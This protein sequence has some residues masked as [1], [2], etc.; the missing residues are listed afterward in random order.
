[1]IPRQLRL[2][3]LEK[4]AQT[5]TTTTTAPTTP[6]G[7]KGKSQ[8]AS[9]LMPTLANGWGQLVSGI[10]SLVASVDSVILA[11]TNN[12]YNFE[13]LFQNGFPM[14]V[15][16]EYPP[17][18]PTKDA[19]AFGRIIYNMLLNNGLQHPFNAPLQHN[20][21]RNRINMVLQAPQLLK[22]QQVNV[23]GPLGQSNA[24]LSSIRSI[25]LAMLN[26][27]PST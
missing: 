16:T 6:A 23:S 24:N 26:S 14:G 20:D 27:I 10:N 2:K 5:T 19:I 11:G 13:N 4:V 8:P 3:L 17:P 7:N 15:D 18:N 1:M 9:S 22:F 25:L 12:K 21:M